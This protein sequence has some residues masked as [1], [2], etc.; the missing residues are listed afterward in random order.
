MKQKKKKWIS[1]YVIRYIRCKFTG[2]GIT[3][4][5]YGSNMDF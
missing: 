1:W 5:G 4:A 3:R 2:D